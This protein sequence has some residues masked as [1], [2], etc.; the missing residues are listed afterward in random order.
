MSF[1]DLEGAKPDQEMQLKQDD[2]AKIDYPLVVNKFANVHHLTLHFPSNFGSDVTRIYYIG[3]RGQFQHAFRE[4][5]AIAT[6]EARPMADDHKHSL[7]ND[8]HH[9]VC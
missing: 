9:H 2:E 7:P 1:S 8:V 6:Y 4:K 3:L 5:V